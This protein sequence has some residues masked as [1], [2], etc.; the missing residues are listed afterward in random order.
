MCIFIIPVLVVISIYNYNYNIKLCLYKG[1]EKDEPTSSA[2]MAFMSYRWSFEVD[3]NIFENPIS[4]KTVTVYFKTG[5]M[6]AGDTEVY[7]E[8]NRLLNTYIITIKCL[9]CLHCV[10]RI[11]S[12]RV[13]L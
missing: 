4:Q 10:C 5:L 11:R 9:S 8:P 6:V 12:S 1:W 3:G 2:R 7:T 13:S